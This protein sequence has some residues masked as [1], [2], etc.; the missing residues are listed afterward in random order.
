MDIVYDIIQFRYNKK[1]K[2]FYGN[3]N[4]LYSMNV[5]FI[6]PFPNNRKQ[7]YI[8]NT[9]TGSFRR[10]RLHS[11]TKRTMIFTSEDNIKCRIKKLTKA[12]LKKLSKK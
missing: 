3:E 11:E 2:T 9:S 1:V 10:F 7:F 5:T 8:K 4:D 6:Y 12:Q